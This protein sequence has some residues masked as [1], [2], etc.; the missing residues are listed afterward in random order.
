MSTATLSCSVVIPTYNRAELLSHTLASLAGQDMPQDHFE[1]LVVDDGSSDHTRSTVEGFRDRL[2]V[3][4][5][6]KPDEGY[7]A[8]EARNVGISAARGE[9]CVFVDSGVML[10]P[11]CLSAHVAAHRVATA[12]LAV[13]GYVYCF[14]FGDANAASMRADIDVRDPGGTIAR[15]AA[16]RRW[17]DV[18]EAF[19]AKY[20][21]DFADLPAPWLMFWTAD[22]S[23][24]TDLVRSVGMFDA[25]IRQWGCDDLDLGYRLHR[26]GARVVLERRASA[27]HYPH[28]K[29]S[30]ASMA[31]AAA[32]HQYLARKYDAPIVQL[33]LEFPEVNML[34]M[35]DVA[36]ERGIPGTT[37][38]VGPPAR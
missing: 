13:C 34:T 37:E 25:G 30:H 14:E 32:G 38:P 1:V 3:R 18:R 22:A 10:H 35:N 12:P 11:G 19:Y 2:P 9:I 16:T 15:L 4:Y 8:A 20:T 33:L 23:A 17:L 5:F 24:R 26:A 6:F 7:R 27:I 31:L 21:D 28:E 36:R 29:D